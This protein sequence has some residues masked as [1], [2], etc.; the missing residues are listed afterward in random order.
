[1]G[2]AWT[3]CRFKGR[4]GK[5]EEGGIFEGGDTLMHTVFRENWVGSEV[6]N[7]KIA[8]LCHF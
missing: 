5:K 2:G 4:L 1:M 8:S 3:V 7:M 6:A